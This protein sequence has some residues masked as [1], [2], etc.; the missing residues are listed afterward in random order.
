MNKNIARDLT[1]EAYKLLGSLTLFT[2]YFYK[3]RTGREFILPQPVSREC[4]YI[5]IARNLHNTVYGNCNRLM[6]NVPPR[7]GKT[8]QLIHYVAWSLAIYPDSNFI[9]VSYAHKLA[10]KQTQVIRQI[11]THPEYRRLFHVELSKESTAK[12]NFET[13]HGGSVYAVG[14]GGTITGRGAGI[15]NVERFGGAIVADDL[16]KPSEATS[17]VVRESIQ[18]WWHNTLVP[19]RLNSPARTPVIVLGQRVHEDDVPGR[20]IAT[21]KNKNWDTVILKAADKNFNPLHP[22]LF[23]KEQLREM[24]ET[25]PYEFAAQYQ[26]NP[27]PAGGGL[28]K[29][30][31]F[32]L[33]FDEP[34]ILETFITVDTAET[35]KDYN[36]ATVFSFWGVYK[37]KHNGIETEMYAL[38][39]MN[40]WEIRVEPKDLESEFYAFYAICMRHL[41]KPKFAAIEKK[42]TGTTLCSV[43][44]GVQ[45]LRVMELERHKGS[46]SKSDR[47]I[48]IQ[49]YIGRKQ[50]S[51]PSHSK[52]TPICLDHM[53]KI[54]ANDTHRFDDIADT[55]ADA[56][57]IAFIDKI[58]NI[59]HN[60]DNLTHDIAYSRYLKEMDRT[61]AVW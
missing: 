6:I 5:T 53:C 58:I 27:I 57:K 43:L 10:S 4:H 59:Y 41:V 33:Y 19:S 45:G 13:T 44:K 60:T 48:A 40:C 8:E 14:V 18:D 25:M 11:I 52:H 61:H 36:D 15:Q 12:D 3:V 2:Q 50:V 38:H 47:F 23:T 51:L 39:W 30:E 49:Q 35:T 16:H 32:T 37:I 54:T 31:W 42:S 28:F 22:G 7:H 56:I 34:E 24:S 26:Q 21:D 1:D 55:C 20:L 9:Y 29:R 17:E 46:G